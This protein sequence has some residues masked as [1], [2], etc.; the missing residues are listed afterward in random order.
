D[1]LMDV[2]ATK[3]YRWERRPL[4]HLDPVLLISVLALGIVGL[5]TIYSAT[6]ASLVA[7]RIDPGFFLK[8]QLAFVTLGIVVILVSAS[9]DYRFVKVYAGIIYV[10]SLAL[11]VLVRTPLGTTIRGSQRWFQLFGF[12]LAP[13]ELAKL[14]LVAM[15]AAFLSQLRSSDLSL[16]DLY[17]ATAIAAVPGL[18]VF[19]QPDLGT[20]IVLLAI[21]VGILV[22][23]GARARHLGVLALTAI[24]LI[25]GALQLGLVKDYQIA[26][27]TAFF[28]PQNDPQRSD[29]NRTQAEIAIGSG[30]LLGRGYLKGTQT[31][32][33]FVPEQH[34]DFIFTVIGEEF[35]FVGAIFVLML[36]AL[37][38][39]RAVRIALLAKD[40]FGTYLAAGIASMLAIQVFVNVGMTL[41]I[42]PITGIPLPFVSYGGSSFLTNCAAVGLLLNIHMRRLT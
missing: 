25:F 15:L 29:Y 19:L 27:L 41:G 11:L 22:V 9:F 3:L 32:L 20:S 7:Q 10:A 33:D 21:L 4:R 42:M 12:Q 30:G 31:N 37:L 8:K 16:Q 40:P 14:A 5:I 23:A 1:G 17:R 13:S 26:R 38:I 28:D 24:V 6:H 35:G 34:T 2:V 39:W 18:L 36:F